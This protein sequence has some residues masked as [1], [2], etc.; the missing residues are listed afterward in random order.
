MQSKNQNEYNDALRLL[1]EFSFDA[2]F[3]S[4][5]SICVGQ[6]TAAAKLFGYTSEEIKGKE[7]ITCIHPIDREMLSEK[8]KLDFVAPFEAI[9]IK[10]N[11]KSFS[12]VV[13]AKFMMFH[14]RKYRL[15]S[16]RDISEQKKV[17]NEL[18]E[19]LKELEVI[20]SSIPNVVWRAKVDENGNVSDTYI[21]GSVN[22]LLG[23]PHDSI[24]HDWDKFMSYVDPEHLPALKAKLAEGFKKPGEV[25]GLQYKIQK[26]DGQIA[27][28][29]SSGRLYSSGGKA[30]AYGF[31][32]D[33]TKQKYQE[34]KLRQLNATKDKFFS[35]ISHDLKNPFTAFMGF[36]ELM[37]R[38]VSQGRYDHIEK[39]AKAIL[40]TARQGSE[41][42][43]N[44][45]DWSKSQR[46]HINFRPEPINITEMVQRIIAFYAESA[47]SKELEINLKMSSAV[48]LV[49]DSNMLET[50]LRN[51]ISNAI[52]FSY[53]QKKI[54]IVVDKLKKATVFKVKDNGVGLNHGDIEK[55]FQL[56]NHP[57]KPGTE[58]ERGTGLGLL[59]CKD[60]VDEH[61]GEIGV[62]SKPGH[63]SVFWFT[64]PDREV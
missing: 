7:E 6:N 32:I 8:M 62:E 64:I 5:D 17:Q 50:I 12:C 61:G 18:S 4:K 2:T 42:L 26:H 11:G 54:E 58:K 23:L 41:L 28:L 29:A 1:E 48:D 13:Q 37:I 56:E 15:I 30:Y 9:A 45:L 49:A 24:K 19:R 51:L 16:I 46:G 35:I 60:F 53:R 63:G 10:K 27:W 36:S 21:S 22:Q 20:N 14:N 47:H 52:K 25:L 43:S 59:L 34:E 39:Y 33:I 3:L 38:Q 31:T 57:T 40:Q 55:L 44:L